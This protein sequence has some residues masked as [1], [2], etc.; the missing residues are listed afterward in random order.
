MRPES[1]VGLLVLAF[2]AVLTVFTFKIN[3][4]RMPWQKDNGY[5]IH[6]LFDTISGLE[7]KALVRYAGVE[8]GLVDAITLE[9]GKAKV[10]LKLNPDAKI[11]TDARVEVG[12]L[13]LMGEKFVLIQGGTTRTP[14]LEPENTIDGS[15]PVSMD[16]LMT[17]MSEIG[18]DIKVITSSFR[19]AVGVDQGTNRLTRIV[20]NIDRMTSALANST[21]SNQGNLGEI[22]D[23]FTVISRDLK[24]IIHSNQS[25]V[26]ATMSDLREVV[27]ALAQ[28]MPQIS[29]DIQTIAADLRDVVRDN[30]SNIGTTLDH[31]AKASENFDA[32]VSDLRD[33]V[34]KIDNGE[35]SI[36]K[37]VNEDEFHTNLNSAVK[38]I[39]KA[40]VELRG[41]MGRVSDYRL[42]V[43]YRGEYLSEASE[44][45]SFISIK[46]Q[47]RP[48]KYYLLELVNSP[49]GR[50][51]EEEYE[52]DFE[53]E[54]DY[55]DP[56]RFTVR[57]WD[58]SD[59]T[60]SLQFAKIY[61]NLTFRGGLIE[62]TGGFGM[63]YQ[64]WRDRI[65]FSMDAWDFSRD[66][67][68]HLKFGGRINLFENFYVSAGWDDF[69]ER[70]NDQDSVF[71]GGGFFIEDDDLKMLLG[72]L[73][74]VSGK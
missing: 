46:I 71:F 40:A 19:D 6:V 74:F 52:Y 28:T 36:G 62:S 49:E 7:T 26:N 48:D 37:L 11:R 55:P 63:D 59:L 14:W 25:N 21:D 27:A 61:H 1:K 47:P 58:K 64:L 12:S 68:P 3:G 38:S 50:Y 34:Q 43:G 51:I 23:N 30:R 70:D 4:D 24:D 31:V 20:E 8:I 65:Q 57:R 60:Y 2:I 9:N 54:S 16:Q 72:F 39:D 15:A 66:S 67:N 33:V 73:P 13:G 5:R 42:F 35:G 56:L 53:S 18:D 45:K 44:T 32:T 22:I 17:S 29:Q 69:L 41:F 10:T